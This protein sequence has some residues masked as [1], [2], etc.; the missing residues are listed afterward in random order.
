MLAPTRKR[1]AELRMAVLGRQRVVLSARS[2]AYWGTCQVVG[3]RTIASR[4]RQPA[5]TPNQPF[6]IKRVAI[7]SHPFR[8]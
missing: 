7:S 1:L 2:Q 4:L 5:K 8:I 3:R 6:V